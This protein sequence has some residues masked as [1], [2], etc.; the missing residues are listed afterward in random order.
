LQIFEL[1]KEGRYN[2]GTKRRSHTNHAEYLNLTSPARATVAA[3]LTKVSQISV[4]IQ[5]Q[6][7]IQSD[8]KKDV[9]A[10]DPGPSA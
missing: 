8:E 7:S 9:A 5:K 2:F 10:R 1:K 4:L 6:Q 3:A